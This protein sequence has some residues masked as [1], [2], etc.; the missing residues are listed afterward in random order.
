VRNRPK[1]A[2][3]GSKRAKGDAASRQK[4]ESLTKLKESGNPKDAASIFEE[5]L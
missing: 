5:M 4:A 3:P 1:M 2:R